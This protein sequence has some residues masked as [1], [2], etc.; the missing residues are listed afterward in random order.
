MYRSLKSFLS[1]VVPLLILSSSLPAQRGAVTVPVNL[2]QLEDRAAIIVH[3]N[4]ESAVVEPH[5][6]HQHLATV[7]VRMRIRET[8][9]GAVQGPV[10]TFRQ[11]IWDIRDRM[12]AA[13]YRKGQELVLFLNPTTAEG[14]TAPVALEQGRFQVMRTPGGNVQAVNGH[15]NA[16]LL[17]GT[18]VRLKTGQAASRSVAIASTHRAG[19]LDLGDLR[20]MVQAIDRS[21]KGG[22]KQ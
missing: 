14:L 4:V 1:L 11:F 13:G 17:R 15:A 12:D 21:G 8:W 19:P 16:G 18:E 10:Y 7:L 20:S 22:R 5:P 3:G 2:V 9:K 6:D